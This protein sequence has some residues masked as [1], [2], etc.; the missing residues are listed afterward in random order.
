MASSVPVLAADDGG[1]LLSVS[2]WTAVGLV[3]A[4]TVVL[5]ASIE[6]LIKAMVQTALR[7]RVSAFALAVVVSGFEFDNVAFGLMNGFRELQ[8][9]SFGLAIGNAVSIFGLVLA[10]C[11]IAYPFEIDVPR[12]Y[13]ALLVAAPF[14]LLPFILLGHFTAIAGVL[15]VALSIGVFAYIYRRECEIDRTFVQSPE[16]RHATV[17]ADGD[18]TPASP[19][20]GPLEP[21]GRHDWFWPAMMVVAIAGIVVGAEGSS[22]GVEGVLETWNLSGTFVGITLVTLLYTVDDLLLAVEPLRLGHYDITVGGIIGSLLFFV[23]ANV[24]IV[25]LVGDVHVGASTL[26][27]HFPVLVGMTA[28]SGYFLRRGHL[29]RWQG[30]VLLGLYVTYLVVNVLLFSSIPVGE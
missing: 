15:L 9:V 4:G 28:L 3:V 17:R 12:D 14:V 21:I 29:T 24:G 1:E 30:I 20:P 11:I 8:N 7:F 25:A 27:L 13:L 16:V 10:L 22:A 19:L 26:Y 18:E 6:V 5:L 23:T 2:G